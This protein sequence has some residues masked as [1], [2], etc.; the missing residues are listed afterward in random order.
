MTNLRISQLP[1]ATLMLVAAAGT[2]IGSATPLTADLNAV[3]SAT[4]G[5]AE[6]V[7]LFPVNG[8]V[9]VIVN[10]TAITIYVYPNNSGS[11]QI[12]NGGVDVPVTIAPGKSKS[13]TRTVPGEFYTIAVT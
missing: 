2:T 12:D 11:S 4:L 13:F 3:T 9:Q 5:V 7:S 8:Q 1:A 6:G 10:L